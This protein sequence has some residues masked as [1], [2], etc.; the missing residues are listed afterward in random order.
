VDVGSSRF[1]KVR[2]LGCLSSMVRVERFR[3]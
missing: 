3:T 2:D 1:N